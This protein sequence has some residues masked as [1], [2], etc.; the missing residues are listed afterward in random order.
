MD[1]PMLTWAVIV[2][3]FVVILLIRFGRGI[4]RYAHAHHIIQLGSEREEFYLPG[5]RLNDNYEDDDEDECRDDFG[6][7]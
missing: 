7:C 4:Y 5:D 2:G 1:T 3:L 6:N